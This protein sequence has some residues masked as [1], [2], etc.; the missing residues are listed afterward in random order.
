MKIQG[1]D[2]EQAIEERESKISEIEK[3]LDALKRAHEILFGPSGKKYRIVKDM[4]Q[5]KPEPE[6][7]PRQK[8]KDDHPWKKKPKHGPAPKKC[9][10]C[11]GKHLAKGLCSKCY[12]EQKR[13][14]KTG[15]K[16]SAP[17][18]KPKFKEETIEKHGTK[19]ISSCCDDSVFDGTQHDFGNKYCRGCKQPCEW[20][21]EPH[22]ASDVGF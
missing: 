6:P 2:I 11:D 16:K 14:A 10:L 5:I 8:P 1:A 21:W 4:E 15:N 9:S 22:N 19:K 7:K 3:E 12:Y 18:L 13:A 17:S 20:K